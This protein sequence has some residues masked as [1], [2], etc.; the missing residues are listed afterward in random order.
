MGSEFGDEAAGLM[1]ADH[2]KNMGPKETLVIRVEDRPENFTERI[3]RFKPTHILFVQAASFGGRPGE[4]MLL[5]IGAHGEGLHESPL[6]TLAH[7]LDT[8]L[9]AHVRLLIIEPRG[10]LG[11]PSQEI[12]GAARRVAEEIASTLI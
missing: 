3:R 5:P 11:D 9:S 7:Y 6:T 8:M 4:A 12:V 2:L 10:K 1:V